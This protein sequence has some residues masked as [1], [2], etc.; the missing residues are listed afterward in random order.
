M[1]RKALKWSI[2]LFIHAPLEEPGGWAFILGAPEMEHFF[3]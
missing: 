2:S 3:L 1:S